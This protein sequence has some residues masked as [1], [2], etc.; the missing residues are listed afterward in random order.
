M[1]T[2]KIILVFAV[3]LTMSGSSC[4]WSSNDDDSDNS[5]GAAVGSTVMGGLLG[6]GLGAAIGSASG[7]A[8]KTRTDELL[9]VKPI[10]VMPEFR[11]DEIDNN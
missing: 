4:A 11:R 7:N 9:L 10:D 5:A 1:E 2:L 3:I 6:A 8:G